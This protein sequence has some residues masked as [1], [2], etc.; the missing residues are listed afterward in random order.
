MPFSGDV[1]AIGRRCWFEFRV[2][3]RPK[4]DAAMVNDDTM[5]KSRNEG[6]LQWQ[7]S[8]RSL[9]QL[10]I[11]RSWV[12]MN[13]EIGGI[14]SYSESTTMQVKPSNAYC[15]PSIPDIRPSIKASSIQVELH[16]ISSTSY[17]G[18]YFSYNPI[19]S[20]CLT[21]EIVLPFILLVDFKANKHARF[22]SAPGTQI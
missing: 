20:E 15:C 9:A 3:C 1:G 17:Q 14:F 7:I 4:C 8:P 19:L 2:R 16:N 22:H 13:L 18:S 10:S 21:F 11:I 5:V 6:E 12:V